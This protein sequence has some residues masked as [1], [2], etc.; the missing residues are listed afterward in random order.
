[1]IVVNNSRDV[2]LAQA[3]ARDWEASQVTMYEG[4]IR[5]VTPHQYMCS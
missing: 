1:M 3:K 4:L 2:I 5:K